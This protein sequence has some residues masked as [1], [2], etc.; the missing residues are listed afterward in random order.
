M[1]GVNEHDLSEKTNI[2]NT[3]KVKC[4]E[5]A[6]IDLLGLFREKHLQYIH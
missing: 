1:K 6:D 3:Q 4:I 2:N 5:Y